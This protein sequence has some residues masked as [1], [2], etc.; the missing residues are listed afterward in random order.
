MIIDSRCRP[1]TKE[2]Q[3]AFRNRKPVSNLFQLASGVEP[4]SFNQDSVELMFKEM[5]QMGIDK[6]VVV[7]RIRPKFEVTNGSIAEVVNQYP[8][9]LFGIAGIDVWGQYHEP[10]AE[11]DKA[12]R[13][14]KLS[15]ICIEPGGN[16]R[17][18]HYDDPRLF[19]LYAK[20]DELKVP[21]FM[22][23]A[24]KQGPVLN[25]THPERLEPVANYFPKL[26]IVAAH[27]CYPYVMEMIG[28]ALRCPNV[29]FSSDLYTYWPGGETYIEAAS[30]RLSDQFLFASA[31]PLSPF[32]E[33]VEKLKKYQLK[34]AV[35]EKI[36]RRNI[37]RV[38]GVV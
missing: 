2:F 11:T 26:K 10:M 22:T 37:E 36:C 17:A 28:V 4:P 18:M 23:T 20:C 30:Q 14:L 31:Y 19:P 12:V 16:Q 33:A 21:V 27:G 15:G 32:D 1:P 8:D 13:T 7:G 25:Y 24:F 35:M 9:R 5:D 29:Y 3:A 38:L 34:S 6:G